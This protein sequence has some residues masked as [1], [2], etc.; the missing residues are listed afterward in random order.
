MA[1]LGAVTAVIVLVLGMMAILPLGQGRTALPPSAFGPS[2]APGAGDPSA[3]DQVIPSNEPIAGDSGAPGEPVILSPGD[4]FT[5]PDDPTVEVAVID[6]RASPV[7]GGTQVE[8]GVMYRNTGTDPFVVDPT[9]WNLLASDGEF[10]AMVGVSGHE[11]K[12]SPLPP[13]STRSA[14]L[15]GI[16]HAA[17]DDTF[18]SY[19][20]AAG[21]VLFA[22]PAN[23]S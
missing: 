11:L 12:T 6:V 19:S 23:G 5:M 7:N 8:V 9:A 21:D 1:R 14:R 10:V 16:V 20:N 18:V 15:Q 2:S 22:V 17:V 3:P 4:G 13:A